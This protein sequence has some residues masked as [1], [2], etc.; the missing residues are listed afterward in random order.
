MDNKIEN[1]YYTSSDLSTE[2][3]MSQLASCGL[4]ILP[5]ICSEQLSFSQLTDQLASCYLDSPFGDRSRV[6]GEDNIQSVSVGKHPIDFHFEWGNLPFRPELLMFCCVEPP[7]KEGETILCDS[8]KVLDTLSAESLAILKNNQLKYAD[9]LPAWIIDYYSNK[10][11]LQT[12][13]QG[14][15][16]AYLHALENYQID[17][18]NDNFVKTEFTTSA[19]SKAHFSD[20]DVIGGNVLSSIY[21]SKGSQDGY[22]SSIS[23]ADN[24]PLP[25]CLVTEIKEAMDKNKLEVQ[26]QKGDVVLIDNTR[27]LHGRNRILDAKRSILLAS[28][29][30]RQLAA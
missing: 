22:T 3:L 23:F 16:L 18:V 17:S 30:T 20:A 7:L 24:S 15:F 1:Y 9:L 14:D 10:K 27:F 8:S 13:F 21:S 5:Q 25:E 29:Y 26:W 2:K 11:E 28:A 6:S 4:V 19:I 12:Q